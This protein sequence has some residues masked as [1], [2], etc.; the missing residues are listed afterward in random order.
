MQTVNTKTLPIAMRYAQALL[1]FSSES[2]AVAVVEKEAQILLVVLR[3]DGKFENA[4]N[5][6]HY[7]NLDSAAFFDKLSA[8][9][10]LSK[11]MHGLLQL[12][13]RNKRLPC[14]TGVLQEFLRVAAKSRNE[15][16][17]VI[18]TAAPLPEATCTELAQKIST[19]LKSTVLLKN[20]VDPRILGGAILSVD[21]KMLDVSLGQYLKT[22]EINAKNAL[23]S[24]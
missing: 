13:G 12:L 17:G 2:G 10:K 22:L 23:N 18:T 8:A 14:L 9:L 16:A 5:I 15:I 24:L 6:L 20:Q 1:A 4:L 21:S 3:Q 19:Y 11:P 7:Q